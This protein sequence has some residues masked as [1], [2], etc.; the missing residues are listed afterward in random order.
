MSE[1]S[2]S[3]DVVGEDRPLTMSRNLMELVN[4]PSNQAFFYLY[5]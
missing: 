5:K 1:S 4:D 2:Q 3:G